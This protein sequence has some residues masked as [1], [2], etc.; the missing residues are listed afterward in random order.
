MKLG[1]TDCHAEIADYFL[2]AIRLGADNQSK[3][4]LSQDRAILAADVLIR[5]NCHGWK[6]HALMLLV[7][8]EYCQ[9]VGQRQFIGKI[10]S[11]HDKC[12]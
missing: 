12:R 6:R 1:K 7:I 5:N 8:Q 9:L 10:D 11:K 4:L 2:A 3:A